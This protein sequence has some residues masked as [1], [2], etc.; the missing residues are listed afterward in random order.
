[1]I[2]LLSQLQLVTISFLTSFFFSFIFVYLYHGYIKHFHL[3]FRIILNIFIFLVFT[4]FYFY[5]CLTIY[6]AS[7]SFYQILFLF[8][9]VYTFYNFYFPYFYRLVKRREIKIYNFIEKSKKTLYNL[10][11]RMG[12]IINGRS[13]KKKKKDYAND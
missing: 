13:R 5:L 10:I 7:F 3:V 1:M 12:G 2:D 8:L 9:G 6:D 11:K 4:S